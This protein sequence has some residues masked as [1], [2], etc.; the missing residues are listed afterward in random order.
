MTGVKRLDQFGDEAAIDS[1]PVYVSA[2]DYDDLAAKFNVVMRVLRDHEI[3]VEENWC[4]CSPKVTVEH[5]M[6]AE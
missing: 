4:W 6:E 1:W 2:E 5:R 3:H